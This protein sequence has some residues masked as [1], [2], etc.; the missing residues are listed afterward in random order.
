M[1]EPLPDFTGKSQ[2][3]IDAYQ[4][5]RAE[6]R[7][8]RTMPKPPPAPA[9]RSD[10]DPR[11]S[12]GEFRYDGAQPVSYSPGSAAQR[13]KAAML[14]RDCH[15]T[16]HDAHNRA[17]LVDHSAREAHDAA[18]RVRFDQDRFNERVKLERDLIAAGVTLRTDAA[19]TSS[20]SRAARERMIVRQDM[21]AWTPQD[22]QPAPQPEYRG[23]AAPGTNRLS[24][25]AA[26][27]RLYNRGA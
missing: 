5:M 4:A 20:N 3:Y 25:L 2:A 11:I 24:A 10:A 27:E 26:R 9:M 21:Y 15:V 13:A 8:Q 19:D 18:L 17:G 6:L 7:A 16:R 14:E 23:D 12:R 1:T 22:Q